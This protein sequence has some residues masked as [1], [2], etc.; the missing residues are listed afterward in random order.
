MKTKLQKQ[1]ARPWDDEIDRQFD[2]DRMKAA[3]PEM[4]DALFG[5]IDNFHC[6][7]ESTPEQVKAMQ[8]ACNAL[9]KARGEVTP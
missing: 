4:Y 6:D 8:V 3:A 7:Q 1:E 2:R 9:A 5:M